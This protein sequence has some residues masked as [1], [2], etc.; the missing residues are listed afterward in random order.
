[1]FKMRTLTWVSLLVSLLVGTVICSPARAEMITIDTSAFE[2]AVRSLIEIS[3]AQVQERQQDAEAWGQLGEVLHAHGIYVEA[4]ESY[5][6]AVHLNPKEYRWFYLAALASSGI[7]ADQALEFFLKDVI[8]ITLAEERHVITFNNRYWTGWA[9]TSDPYVA[10]YSLWAGF[11][12]EFLN[13]TKA[14]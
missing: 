4:I 2:Q 1:M 13:I 7:A 12:L 6:H 5:E 11:L 10:P 9:N 8:E 3:I 14:N